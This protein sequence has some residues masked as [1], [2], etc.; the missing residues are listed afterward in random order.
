MTTPLIIALAAWAAFAGETQVVSDSVERIR[1]TVELSEDEKKFFEEFQQRHDQGLPLTD[2]M[3]RVLQAQRVAHDAE[4]YMGRSQEADDQ[5]QMWY[6]RFN[7]D[8]E[9]AGPANTKEA[10]AHARRL[11]GVFKKQPGPLA[12]GVLS[13]AEGV[14]KSNSRSYVLPAA[15]GGAYAE[16]GDHPSAYRNYDLA[17]QRGDDRADT[18]YGR[19]A[20]AEQLGDM[21]QA[22][23]DAAAALEREPAH[24]QAL[25]LF[26]LTQSRAPKV[27]IG[28]VQSP[29]S[30]T[31]GG[32]A[33]PA[34]L[35][36][37]LQSLSPPSASGA[38]PGRGQSASLVKA[39]LSD[40]VVG[41]YPA[42]FEKL[43]KA[44]A[45]DPENP[46]PYYLRARMSMQIG[47]YE[48]AARDAGEALRLAP[49]SVALL[50][51]RA[52]AYNRLRRYPEAFADASAAL[53]LNPKSA[54]GFYNRAY[55]RAGLGQRKEALEDLRRAASLAPS[56]QGLLQKAVEL[57]ADAD[58]TL[59][60]SGS[61]PV[62]PRP[63]SRGRS[64]W[65]LYLLFA[66]A[67]AG[68]VWA[69]L[70]AGF[71]GAE[72]PASDSLLG[73]YSVVRELA[74]GGMGVVYEAFDPGL[75]RKVAIKIMRS[76]I[77]LDPR[78]RERFLTE[79]RTVAKMRHPNIVEIYSIE[80]QGSDA[81]LIFEYVE[82]RTLA[83]VL[84][85][86]SRLGL[87]E[88]KAV[89]RG[90]CAALEYSHELGIVHRDLKPSNIMIDKD[91]LARVMDFGVA[92]EAKDAMGRLSVTRTVCGTPPYMAPE[93]EGGVVGRSTDTYALAVCLYECLTGRL[94]FE[95][96]A[97]AKKLSGEYPPASTLVPGLP[98][99]LDAL[100]ARGLDPKPEKRFDSA[101]GF[102]ET[103]ESLA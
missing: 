90:V 47:D 72:A 10:D 85:E 11:V 67:S 27:K 18:Y 50:N 101:R 36:T 94:P 38:K 25:A 35:A 32:E 86:K 54:L 57:P 73:R 34:A 55:A 70:R 16:Q 6:W 39:A 62:Q 58:L 41:G 91:G 42:A 96:S 59:L 102:L 7:P 82:G 84:R 93:Q 75:Q 51:T 44:I 12:G 89:F 74:A 37:E 64:R 95:G 20:A 19:G 13:A 65:P 30:G 24:P 4:K 43:A 33:Q 5:I 68:I 83:Q 98:K 69:G 60:L 8:R 40:V 92:R 79:A 14:A 2:E 45:A 46:Q 29:L 48:S 53:R 31:P 1:R 61:G 9:T 23:L 21:A 49:Q 17:I 3:R 76:E 15:V 22:N 78:E 28:R 26:K 63:G 103:L 81:Y 66:L 100:V 56:L 87:A 88:A 99:G 71:G 80:E 77:R 97:I 52:M